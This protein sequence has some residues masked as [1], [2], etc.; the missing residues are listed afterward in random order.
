MIKCAYFFHKK[1]FTSAHVTFVNE[2][3]KKSFM[4]KWHFLGF[5]EIDYTT[6]NVLI[7]YLIH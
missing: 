4:L 7:M 5:W 6:Y 3:K 1:M 2:A